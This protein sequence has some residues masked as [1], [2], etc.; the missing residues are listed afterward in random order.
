MLGLAQAEKCGGGK[1]QLAVHPPIRTG[2]CQSAGLSIQ[3]IDECL[4]QRSV[5]V[6]VR[7][8]EPEIFTFCLAEPQV[9][10]LQGA[11]VA[12]R[13]EDRLHPGPWHTTR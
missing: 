10:L 13:I 5:R 6:I 11:D 3:P 1:E 9:P 8:G 2:E 4:Q 7:L 12:L